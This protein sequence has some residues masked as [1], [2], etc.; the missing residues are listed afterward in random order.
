MN[1]IRVMTESLAGSCKNQERFSRKRMFKL[2]LEERT[3]RYQ[4]ERRVTEGEKDSEEEGSRACTTLQS[5]K[6]SLAGL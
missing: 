6:V 2:S 4:V 3:G 1:A 5:W